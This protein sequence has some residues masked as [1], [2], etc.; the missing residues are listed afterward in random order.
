MKFEGPIQEILDDARAHMEKTIEHFKHELSHFR[1][2]R[3]TP[4]MLED[5]RVEYYGSRMPL[6]QVASVNAPKSHPG[7]QS[8]VEPFK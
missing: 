5:I 7:S 8:G 6:E 1:A 2:G 3:A 4:S